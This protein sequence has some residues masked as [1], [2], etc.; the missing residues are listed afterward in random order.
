MFF[1]MLLISLVSWAVFKLFRI[2]TGSRRRASAPFQQNT[3]RRSYEGK[4]VD[5]QFEEVDGND[6]TR[7]DD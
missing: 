5:A 2:L 3:R 1:R 6:G 4:A 7:N